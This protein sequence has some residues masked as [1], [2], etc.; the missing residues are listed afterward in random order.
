MH[1][2]PPL[3]SVGCLLACLLAAGSL[4]AA[5]PQPPAD[6]HE[7]LDRW[8][9]QEKIEFDEAAISFYHKMLEAGCTPAAALRWTRLALFA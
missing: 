8:L 2:L 4:S 5:K 7:E 3:L 9:I 1:R 6:P